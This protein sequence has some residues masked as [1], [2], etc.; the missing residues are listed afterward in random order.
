MFPAKGKENPKNEF[1]RENTRQTHFSVASQRT[2]R[3]TKI[4]NDFAC[5]L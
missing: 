3:K 2:I 1:G 4:K 5:Q